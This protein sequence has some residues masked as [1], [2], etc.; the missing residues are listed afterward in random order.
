M[1]LT[2]Y[3][4]LHGT[5]HD[6]EV[7]HSDVFDIL[8]SLDVSKT[9]GIDNISPKIFKYY[10]APL[11][12]VIC[13]LFSVSLKNSSIPQEWRT[14]CVIP[15]YKTGDKSSVCNYRPISLLCILSKVLERIVY[16]NIFKHVHDKLAKHQFGFLP[17]RSTLPQLL[18]FTDKLFE[19]ESEVNVVCMDFRKA[20]D[21]VSHNGLLNKLY[22]IGITAGKLWMWLHE[23]LLQR[24]QCVRI[25]SSLST[26]CNVLS[27]VPQGSVLDRPLQN[28]HY[29]SIQ[30]VRID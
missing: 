26:F 22:F 15:V 13:H 1:I 21:S 7:S 30:N 10:A 12:L 9:S 2:Q 20:F 14:H 17:N 23:Y 18:L 4:V 5:L 8:T 11:L 24:S 28:Y 25:G 16:N 27:G 29:E 3:P 6:I 19:V